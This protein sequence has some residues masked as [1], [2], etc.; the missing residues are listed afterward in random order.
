ML[1]GAENM[2]DFFRKKEL[3]LLLLICLGVIAVP[4]FAQAK[5]IPAAEIKV[6]ITQYA[7]TNMPWAAGTLRLGFAAGLADVSLADEEIRCVVQGRAD[8]DYIGD[9]SFTVKYY[10]GDELLKQQ[11]VHVS[12]EVQRDIVVAARNLVKG[13]EITA[14]DVTVVK[15]WIKR[16]STNAVNSIADAIGKTPILNMRQDAEITRNVIKEPL[17][18]KRGGMVRIQLEEGHLNITTLGVS[19]EDGIAAAVIKVKNVS[20]NKIL[21]ARVV[22]D[23]TVRVEF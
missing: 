18:V 7:E 9:T 6:L 10:A 19:E 11:N 14:A 2:S 12:M 20:S 8:E 5:I 1:L 3:L 15:R 17:L 16:L 23:A 4:V 13:Q 22:G 21:Y